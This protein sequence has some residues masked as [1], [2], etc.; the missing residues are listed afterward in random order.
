MPAGANGH[1]FPRRDLDFYFLCARSIVTSKFS[2][3]R[4]GEEILTAGGPTQT[5]QRK[6]KTDE[7]AFL[8]GVRG[9]WTGFRSGALFERSG[10]R[11]NSRKSGN[12]NRTGHKLGLSALRI[13]VLSSW[14]L[15]LPATLF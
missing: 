2:G 12:W 10:L 1:V 4:S 8:N 5:K 13:R 7:K 9:K 15:L 3:S 6:E 11:R 14:R